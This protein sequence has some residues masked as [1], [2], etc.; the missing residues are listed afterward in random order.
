MRWKRRGRDLSCMDQRTAYGSIFAP[1]SRLCVKTRTRPSS[2][3]SMN[4]LY[5]PTGGQHMRHWR[6]QRD[7]QITHPATCKQRQLYGTSYLFVS[8]ALTGQRDETVERAALPSRRGSTR[9]RSSAAGSVCVVDW[10]A[11]LAAASPLR[12]TSGSTVD[13]RRHCAA[14]A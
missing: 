2:G 4:C 13:C 11:A 10:C 3:I 5:K 14:R 9:H 7:C 12:S 6:G 8:F 1:Q